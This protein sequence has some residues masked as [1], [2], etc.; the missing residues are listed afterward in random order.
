MTAPAVSTGPVIDWSVNQPIVAGVDV[1]VEG[2]NEAGAET[3]VTPEVMLYGC[4]EV[5]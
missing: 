3:P 5:K 2:R 1:T 4:F